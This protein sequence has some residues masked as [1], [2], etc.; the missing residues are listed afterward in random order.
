MTN[1]S[2][3]QLAVLGR[4][5]EDQPITATDVAAAE[6]VRQQSVAEI[7][8]TLRAQG[9]VQ[10]E[11][12]PRDRRKLLL[13]LT[14]QGQEY[15]ESIQAYRGAWL[16]RAIDMHVSAEERETLARA[17]TI[18]ARLADAQVPPLD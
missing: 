2:L 13:S 12:H 4:I 1:R 10:G 17:V 3:S 9:L 14:P 6:H 8:T 18:M 5:A 11:P 15:V 7:V 16:A